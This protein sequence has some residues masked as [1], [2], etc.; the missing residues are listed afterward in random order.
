MVAAL[1]SHRARRTARSKTQASR[2]LRS[3]FAILPEI[4]IMHEL[5]KIRI[6]ALTANI[7]AAKTVL[8]WK[9]KVFRKSTCEWLA[10]HAYN[11]L[12]YPTPGNQPTCMA[13]ASRQKVRQGLTG[14][15]LEPT[16]EQTLDRGPQPVGIER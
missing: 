3:A 9:C 6:G 14:Y 8:Y 16:P 2:P 13:S 1:L 12:A 7:E 11:R 10:P 4:L 5:T 15:N